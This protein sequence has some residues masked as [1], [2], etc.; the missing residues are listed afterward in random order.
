MPFEATVSRVA[1]ITAPRDQHQ[2]RT[3]PGG[4]AGRSWAAVAGVLEERPLAL[5]DLDRG[6]HEAERLVGVGTEGRDGRDADHDDEG[7][8]DG[9]LDCGRAIFLAQEACGPGDPLVHNSPLL[10]IPRSRSQ[11]GL[12]WPAGLFV[13]SRVRKIEHRELRNGP[14]GAPFQTGVRYPHPFGNL[15]THLGKR[16]EEGG[17]SNKTD[18]VSSFILHPSSF[19][20]G[21]HSFASSSYNEFALVE[22]EEA[23]PEER[24]PRLN[25]G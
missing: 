5:L 12:A 22:D 9:V 18:L 24:P 6:A 8:H 23:I 3:P 21:A 20:K 13:I 1:T 25:L 14:L 17:R 10:P 4:T 15:A 7:Q 11:P 2:S 19:Q 16:K